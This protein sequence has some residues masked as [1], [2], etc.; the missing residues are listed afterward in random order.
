LT[1][2]G[3][4]RNFDREDALTKAMNIFWKYGYEPTS[5]T[6][7]RDVM[8]LSSASLYNAWNSKEEL[9][10]DAV[11]LYL[12]KCGNAFKFEYI[13]EQSAVAVIKQALCDSAEIQTNCEHPYGCMLL[14]SMI[15]YSKENEHIRSKILGSVE[16]Y[17][18]LIKL[19]HN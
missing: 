17:R 10:E 3:R 16:N 4:P 13:P 9:F 14:L 12:E 19:A 6:Q 1:K 2:A 5:L 11:N 18:E 8:G 7:L 15:N